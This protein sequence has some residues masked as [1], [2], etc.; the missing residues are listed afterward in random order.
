MATLTNPGVWVQLGCDVALRYRLC[1]HG[2]H[3]GLDQGAGA[4]VLE[5]VDDDTV[6]H[7][8]PPGNHT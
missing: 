6:L 1:S 7:G 5:A 2:D 3:A 4:G 8:Q